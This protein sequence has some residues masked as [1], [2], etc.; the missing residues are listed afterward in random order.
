MPPKRSARALRGN[1]PMLAKRAKGHTHDPAVAELLERHIADLKAT[2]DEAFLKAKWQQLLPGAPW[3]PTY[4]DCPQGD[5][6]KGDTFMKE[7]ERGDWTYLLPRGA[8]GGKARKYHVSFDGAS[9][10]TRSLVATRGRVER[11]TDACLEKAEEH[12]RA[13]FYLRL[14]LVLSQM[15][16][17]TAVGELME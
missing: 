3:P 6:K 17:T 2:D 14:A 8:Y 9:F 15:P 11:R 4:E 16:G 7:S 1:A 10:N 12:V 5:H 13:E